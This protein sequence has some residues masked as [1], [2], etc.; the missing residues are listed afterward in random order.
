MDIFILYWYIN[1]END[2]ID[3]LKLLHVFVYNN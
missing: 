2:R 3:Y 1:L